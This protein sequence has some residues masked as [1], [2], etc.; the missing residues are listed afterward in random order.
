MTIFEHRNVSFLSNLVENERNASNLDENS[1]FLAE[2]SLLLVEN[3]RFLA[4][5]IQFWTE[6]SRLLAGNSRSENRHFPVISSN[7]KE[8]HRIWLKIVD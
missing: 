2:N 4:E 3:S 1:R 6:N 8:M 7:I 5:N